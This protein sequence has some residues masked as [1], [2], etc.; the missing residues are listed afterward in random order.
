MLSKITIRRY[1][2]NKCDLYDNTIVIW[3]GP[4][5]VIRIIRDSVNNQLL[6]LRQK[7]DPS[8]TPMFLYFGNN[9][10]IRLEDIWSIEF[11]FGDE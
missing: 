3:E 4:L 2:D 1:K 10:S 7:E 8:T 5:D 6:W 9:L 11:N